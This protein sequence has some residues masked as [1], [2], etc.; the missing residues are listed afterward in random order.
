MPS[1]DAETQLIH[2][3]EE[4]VSRRAVRVPPYPSTAMQLQAVLAR[5]DYE[6]DELVEAMRSDP[7]FAGNLLRL[8]NS[9]L[10]RRGQE[11][12]SVAN[13][14][15]RVGARELT[16][17]AMA[18]AVSKATLDGVL[19]PLRRRAWRESLASALLSERLAPLSQ[20]EPGEAF[21]AGLLHDVGRV[22]A[23]SVLEEAL[24]RQPDLDPGDEVL[25]RLV[26]RFHVAFGA[27]V[28]ERWQLPGVLG[29]VITTHHDAH[30]AQAPLA[31]VVLKADL[32]VALLESERQVTAAMLER[33]GLTADEARELEHL[34]PG[35][36]AFLSAL[37]VEATP[38]VGGAAPATQRRVSRDWLCVEPI[39]STRTELWPVRHFEPH[40]AEATTSRALEV[41][42]LLELRLTPMQLQ[43][44]ALVER[45]EAHGGSNFVLFR[46]F[47][48]SAEGARQW[49]AVV[50]ERRAA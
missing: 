40:F 41:G 18:A 17:L 3:L 11:V 27:L 39:G 5:D 47:A 37:E 35:V 7:A 50:A 45:N 24:A 10:Y 14:V 8:A 48:L 49:D 38:R 29:A 9:P 34:L 31:S 36:P 2:A 20:H 15:L 4:A 25:W 26:D 6:V 32:A 42:Q 1:A 33:A 30:E 46:P 16:R 12:T 44:W 13:A 23:L 19:L 28:A 21:V 43:F 22:L